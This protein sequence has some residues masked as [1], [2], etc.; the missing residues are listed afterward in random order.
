MKPRAESLRVPCHRPFAFAAWALFVLSFFLPSFDNAWGWQC[1]II[2]QYYWPAVWEG[3][4]ACIHLVLL[5]FAN[6]FMLASPWFI[7]RWTGGPRLFRWLRRGSAASLFLTAAL[8]LEFGKDIGDL[9]I[10]Y[11]V[12]VFS[13]GLLAASLVRGAVGSPLHRVIPN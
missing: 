1:A 9:R 11:F 13:F 12:W 5:N 10:G 8:M 6:L 2:I 4:L 3:K 7:L